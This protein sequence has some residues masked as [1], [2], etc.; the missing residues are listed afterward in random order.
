MSEIV[1][2]LEEL[3]AGAML[4]GL[5]PKVL[6]QG[7]SVR[8]VVF[9]GKQDLER[10]LERRIR[11]YRVPNARFV[12]LRDQ[13]AEVCESVKT[14]LQR[15]CDGTGR[16][17]VL[18][19]IACHEIESW[20]LADLHAVQEGLGVPGLARL[21]EKQ[22]YR[23]PDAIGSPSQQLSK[24]APCYQKVGGSRAIGPEMDPTNR[25]SHSCG[26]FVAGIKRLAEEAIA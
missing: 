2:F 14:R 7:L 9:E 21:Q 22:L 20:Y 3:S 4:E 23:E 25:R 19:R 6:P 16:E 15:L 13:D 8:F 18:V 17:G 10:Y 26:V 12:V 1:F 5:L 24:I 11:G